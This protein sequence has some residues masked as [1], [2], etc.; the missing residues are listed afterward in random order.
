MTCLRY[1][2]H[3]NTKAS[4][5]GVWLS[6]TLGTIA[7]PSISRVTVVPGAEHPSVNTEHQ[8]EAG[9]SVFEVVGGGIVVEW[10]CAILKRA[11]NKK[12]T[13]KQKQLTCTLRSTMQQAAGDVT[14]AGVQRVCSR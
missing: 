2:F 5:V 11:Y 6:T 7:A 8:D 13:N 9:W 10:L 12:T 14:Q 1:R 4:H 3:G